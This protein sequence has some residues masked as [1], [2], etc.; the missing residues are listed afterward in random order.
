MLP[1]SLRLEKCPT[2]LVGAGK[3]GENR[4][5]LLKAAGGPLR[6][7]SPETSGPL[8]EAAEAA[9][10]DEEAIRAARV[11]FVGGMPIEEGRRLAAI[12]RDA[13]TLVNVED[14]L[15][16]CDFHVPALVR[17]GDL[18]LA[19]LTGGKAPG[20]ARHIRKYLEGLFG[21]EWAD[22]LDEVAEA[23]LKWRAEGLGLKEVGANV[24]R[25]IVEKGWLK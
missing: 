12:A 14:E 5:A 17:R 24:E 2:V 25:Y 11:L 13:G 18:V 15:D 20:M 21:P 10:A 1:I 6:V 23:R 4:L 19:V 9:E 8:A 22:R 16:L 3:A 7:F